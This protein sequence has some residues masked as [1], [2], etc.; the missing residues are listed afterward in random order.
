VEAVL[1][2]FWREFIAAVEEIKDLR[3]SAVLDALNDLLGAAHLSAREDGAPPRQCP[4]CGTGQLSLKLGR[5]GAFVGCSNYPECRFTRQLGESE[6][7]AKEGIP[8]E[9]V[10][11][12]TDPDTGVPITLHSG[13]FGPYV[14][15]ANGNPTPSPRQARP[16][17]AA[18]GHGP[19]RRRS[20]IR[21]QAAGAAA[22]D[23]PAPRDRKAD[24]RRA[25]PLWS[26]RPA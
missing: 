20:R 21:A 18:Q 14:Q 7:G 19:R 17:L 13:R 25:R 24:H 10:V 8:P 2:D 3:V 22:R 11:L 15:R 5:Y 1:R 12:G 16:H 6:D 26:L 23:R 9:G 4:S